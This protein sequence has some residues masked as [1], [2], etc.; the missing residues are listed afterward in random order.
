MKIKIVCLLMMVL[1]ILCPL[2]LFQVQDYMDQT[3]SYAMPHTS[4]DDIVL[5]KH[6]IIASIYNEFYSSVDNDY[7]NYDYTDISVYDKDIQEKLIDMKKIYEEEINALLTYKVLKPEEL[8]LSDQHFTLN[9]GYLNTRFKKNQNVFPLSQ[10]YEIRKDGSESANFILLKDVHKISKL[11]IY[12]TMTPK[13][14]EEL[15]AITWAYIQYLGLEDLDDWQYTAYGYESYSAKIQ[16]YCDMSQVGEPQ[17]E[18]NVGICPIGQ[19][20]KIYNAIIMQ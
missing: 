7:F 18:L 20:S 2:L 6:P 17:Y 10:I 8:Q 4:I 13:T 14:P 15:K 5:K 19:H 3:K 16:V 12:R 1:T 11:S 9:F